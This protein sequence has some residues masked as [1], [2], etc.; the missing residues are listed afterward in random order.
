MKRNNVILTLL[1]IFTLGLFITGCG[2]NANAADRTEVVFWHV[3][4]GPIGDVLDELVDSFNTLNPDIRVVPVSVGNYNAL[5]QKI[6]ASVNN[7]PVMSQMYESWTMELFMG[8]RLEPIENIASQ[9]DI[10]EI[11]KN[12][13]DIF[14]KDNTFNGTLVSLPFNKSVPTFFYNKD[15]FK[16]FSIEEFPET[17]D[18]FFKTMRKLTVDTDNDGKTDIYGTAFNIN[19]WMFET[20]LLQFNGILV[21]EDLNPKFNSPAAIKAL[22]IDRTILDDKTGYVT[23]GYQHQD[24]FIGEKVA[25]IYGSS[26]SLS[27]IKDNEPTFELGVAPVPSG[28]RDAVLISGTN[29]SVFKNATDNQKRAAYKFIK[30]FISPEIQAI[31]SAKTGYVPVTPL[32][33]E[34]PVL[35]EHFEKNPGLKDVYNQLNYA[36]MEPQAN[37][38]YLGRQMLGEALEYIV[39]GNTDPQ[40]TLDK[41]AEKYRKELD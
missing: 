32:A 15:R 37:I 23:T 12:L 27:F 14:V 1:L 25:T 39:K 11:E 29:V 3:M 28:E 34:Y 24:D 5:S 16:E 7:P 40:K 26:V 20:R 30:W 33:Y 31:W 9:E 18:E 6:M 2:D 8:D 36:H 21:D 17:W 38:W 41:A 4:G 13:F 35:R 22:N 19:T 10:S